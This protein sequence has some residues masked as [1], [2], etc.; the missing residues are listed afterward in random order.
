[1][2]LVRTMNRPT[3]CYVASLSYR[4]LSET[5]TGKTFTPSTSSTAGQGHMHFF[6]PLL[7]L[8]CQFALVYNCININQYDMWL[9]L[10]SSRVVSSS[11]AFKGLSFALRETGPMLTQLGSLWFWVP[12]DYW[13]DEMWYHHFKLSSAQYSPFPLCHLTP[14]DWPWCIDMSRSKSITTGLSLPLQ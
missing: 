7:H 5:H 8:L 13:A 14:K 9:M 6:F 4:V 12:E 3:Y 2:N 10:Q 11:K 1:M